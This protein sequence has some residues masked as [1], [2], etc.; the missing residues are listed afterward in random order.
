MMKLQPYKT[1]NGKFLQYGKVF[2]QADAWKALVALAES[3]N[4]TINRQLESLVLAAVPPAA[5][6]L[7]PHHH[8]QR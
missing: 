7:L 3:A 8:S 6:P 4:T 5:A 2:M 1:T